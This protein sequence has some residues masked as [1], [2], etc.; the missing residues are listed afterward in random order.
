MTLAPG[1]HL[2]PYQIV[3]ALGAGGMGEV[4]KA[5]D[6]RLSRHVAIKVLPAE[7]AA[8]PERL[9]RFEIEARAASALNHPN[10]LTIYD[11]GESGGVSYIA[12]EFV[13]GKTLL[14][15]L[16]AG[17][18]PLRQL[19]ELGTQVADGIAAAHGAGIVHRDLK[20]ANVMVSKDGFVK[21]VDFGLARRETRGD[22]TATAAATG[23]TP[24]VV[25]GTVGYMSPEQTRGEPI[26]YRSDQFSFG[27]VLFE[28]ATGARAF[29]RGS[30]IET[31]SAILRDEPP[32]ISTFRPDFPPPVR[33]LIERCHAK[34]PA[35]RYSSTRDLARELRGIKDHVSELSAERVAGRSI[36]PPRRTGILAAAAAALLVAAA[37]IWLG[38]SGAFSRARVPDLKRLTFRSGSVARALFVPRSNSILYTASWDGQPEG[39]YLTLPESKGADRKLD[40]PVQ[41]PMAYT[42]DGSEVL[43]LLGRPIAELNAFGPLAWWPALGGKPRPALE[44]AGWSD[45]APRGRFL[46]A[47]RVRGGERVLETVDSEGRSVKT[48]FRTVGAISWA[49]I[50][51][52]EKQVAFIHHPS[53]FDNAGEVRVVAIDGSAGRAVSPRYETCTGLAWNA[54]TG[55]VWFTATADSVYSTSL[56][57]ARP[58]G[59][60]RRI[61]SFP[62]VL[63]LQDVS[64]DDGLL[65]GGSADVRLFARKR[66]RNAVN[67]SWL[68]STYVT[69]MSHDRNNVLFIDGTAEEKTLG[70]WIRPLN[71][72]EAVRVADGEVGS[73]SPDD[74]SIVTTTR[75]GKGTPQVVLVTLATGRSVP[76]TS[77]TAPNSSPSFAGPDS[78]LFS[79][80]DGGKIEVWRTGIA[81]KRERRLASGCDRPSANPAGTT[82]L[83]IGGTQ[84]DVLF[85]AP[86]SSAGEAPLR[87][88]HALTGG[89][90]FIY[91]RW[92][93]AGN[94][95]YAV[96]NRGRI[97]RLD[98]ATGAVLGEEPVP[99]DDDPAS[100]R[101]IIAAV[102]S[103]DASVQAYSV[104][105]KSSNLYLFRGL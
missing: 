49:R 7:V 56:W 15:L 93:G 83:C 23:T 101:S 32:P 61:Y 31:L 79:R 30:A 85:A 19:L 76:L 38:R 64:G 22:Q 44:Q 70:T 73:F 69:D 100:S 75:A 41:L 11:V 55:D 20:P 46:A 17:P 3:S 2:G 74:Q 52:D 6:A 48:L 24:G 34:S 54:R 4:Y 67:L 9:R 39:S 94:E 5:F 16:A 63:V 72:G 105:R 28:M 86:I 42:A 97:L 65:V 95:I 90:K 43:V 40:A 77:S 45:W 91:A 18:I 96:T 71:G 66:D 104:S 29:E 35:D 98:P 60:A 89:G 50:S 36:S 51:P 25:L 47:V 92:N 8:D 21:L 33:W 88:V 82:F 1:Q 14:Q 68:G 26:D 103:D 57:A 102:L 27:S 59:T 81:A 78:I 87:T 84:D 13:D 10:I 37:G 99:L 58:G 80:A 62:D 53:R 12:T